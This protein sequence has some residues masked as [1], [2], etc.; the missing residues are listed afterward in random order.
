MQIFVR[1]SLEV[2]ETQTTSVYHELGLTRNTIV[3][4][5]FECYQK[6]MKDNTESRPGICICALL[7]LTVS[8]KLLIVG[9]VYSVVSRSRVLSK[10]QRGHYQSILNECIKT[11][12]ML[13]S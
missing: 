8:V 13:M 9:S 12:I 11:F 4:A 6:I 7:C 1:A 3:T 2:N 10:Y 5:Q